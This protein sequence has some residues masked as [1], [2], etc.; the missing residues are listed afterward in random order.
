MAQNGGN[1]VY[2]IYDSKLSPIRIDT[3]IFIIELSMLTS[4]SISWKLFGIHGIHSLDYHLLRSVHLF[5]PAAKCDGNAT[6]NFSSNMIY[7]D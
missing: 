6:T 4:K 1:D 5:Y 7:Q 2:N 3:A